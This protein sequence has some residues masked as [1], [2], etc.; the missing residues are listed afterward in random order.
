[1]CATVAGRADGSVKTRGLGGFA[2]LSVRPSSLISYGIISAP[3]I[4]SQAGVARAAHCNLDP[5]A[6][7]SHSGVS[8]GTDLGSL[9]RCRVLEGRTAGVGWREQTHLCK[10]LYISSVLADRLSFFCF[11]Q[12]VVYRGIDIN[13][14]S[15]KSKSLVKSECP[16]SLIML[17]VKEC[18]QLY[19][20]GSY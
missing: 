4:T 1:M 16:L 12:P 8:T 14:C 18:L 17:V 11:Q 2:T 13:L 3:C 9:S 6:I 20:E 19:Q 7:L 15:V 10:M 5:R